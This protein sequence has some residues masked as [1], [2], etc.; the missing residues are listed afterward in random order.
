MKEVS[1]TGGS[2]I[3]WVNASWPLATLTARAQELKLSTLGTYTFTDQEVVSFELYGSIPILSSG[4]RI[5]HNRLDYPEKV[6]FWCMGNREAVLDDIRSVGFRP[7]GK[8]VERPSGFAFRWSAALLAI[9]VW[10]VLLL[11]DN[12]FH[13]ASRPGLPGPLT[14]LALVSVFAVSSALPYSAGLQRAVL[15]PGRSINE[16]TPYLR[17][18]QLVTGL[19]SL[20]MGI[21]L[22]ATWST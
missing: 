22:F 2:R 5:N 8:A 10:N 7:Q 14:V 6:V 13:L 15:R 4:I 19:V 1:F 18:L 11:G 17:L 3:G 21:S 9:V 16:I 12:Q 20:G